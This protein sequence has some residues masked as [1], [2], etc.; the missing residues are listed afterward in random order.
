VVAYDQGDLDRSAKFHRESL[1]IY[2]R[3]HDNGGIAVALTTCGRSPAGDDSST[4]Q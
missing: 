3:R 4:Q 1:E 2:G